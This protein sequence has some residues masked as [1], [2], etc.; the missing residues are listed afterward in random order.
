MSLMLTLAL[1]APILAQDADV[2]TARR[3]T[4]PPDFV[5]PDTAQPL[6]QG[7]SPPFKSSTGW[8]DFMHG[9][10]ALGT[11]MTYQYDGT[12][13]AS[14]GVI[15]WTWHDNHYELAV[16]RFL[17]AQRRLGETLAG[18]DWVFEASRRWRLHWSLIDPSGLQL[19][20][21]AGAAY[22]NATDRM[23]GSHLNFAEQLGWRFPRQ[24]NGGQVEFAIR[25]VSNAGL[26]KPNKGQDFLTLAYRF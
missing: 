23:N 6:A 3:P 11:G 1:A 9:H 2:G 15:T 21:G 12:K 17:T 25:H 16:F 24:A 26:K 8:V 20:I 4:Y 5:S 7:A 18:P 13:T 14:L 10:L 19:F 22:K